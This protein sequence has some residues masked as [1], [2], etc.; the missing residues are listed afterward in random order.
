LLASATTGVSSITTPLPT[1]EVTE[2]ATTIV[3]TGVLSATLSAQPSASPAAFVT[4]P[5]LANAP[6]QVYVVAVQRAWMRIIVDGQVSFEGRVMP[7]SAYS[8]SGIERIELFTGDGAGLQVY[9]NEQ[10][11]G[12]LGGFGEV[13]NRIFSIEGI[14]TATPAIP[15][16]STPVPTGSATP[17]STPTGTTVPSTPTPTPKS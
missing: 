10:D 5:G 13:V 8:F 11:L 14:Q 12:L 3:E 4:T 16:T 6:L 2:V 17:A 15:P 1:G 9:F 7:G